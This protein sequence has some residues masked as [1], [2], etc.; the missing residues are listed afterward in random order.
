MVMEPSCKISL[1]IFSSILF[2]IYCFDF[3]HIYVHIKA[4][5]FIV[6]VNL[7]S[8]SFSVFCLP[9]LE[10]WSCS[11]TSVSAW[12]TLSP[13]LLDLHVTKKFVLG[14]GWVHNEKGLWYRLLCALGKAGDVC[15]CWAGQCHPVK[16]PWLPGKGKW[17]TEAGRMWKEKGREKV[18]ENSQQMFKKETKPWHPMAKAL[19]HQELGLGSPWAWKPPGLLWALP[20]HLGKALGTEVCAY[21]EIQSMKTAG[22][23][24]RNVLSASRDDLEGWKQSLLTFK[25]VPG[26]QCCHFWAIFFAFTRNLP[27]Q[28]W[29]ICAL[30][31]FLWFCHLSCIPF[32]KNK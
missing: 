27:P 21:G 9:R 23:E 28:W 1:C 26:S 3:Y 24:K 16:S 10:V 22:G 12:L 11:L 13:S 15:L 18:T 17:R 25:Y 30:H 31:P 6:K 5:L 32:L 7:Q 2:W 4:Q 14:P 8:M 29:D 20:F 19:S